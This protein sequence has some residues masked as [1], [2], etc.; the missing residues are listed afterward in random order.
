MT[1]AIILN[2]KSV[3]SQVNDDFVICADGGYKLLKGRKANCVIGDFD[4]L[5]KTPKGIKSIKYQAMKNQTDGE[6]CIEYAIG[7]GYKNINIYAGLGGRID[8]VMGNLSLLTLAYRLGAKA[9]IKDKDTF[10]Y[11]TEKKLELTVEKGDTIS[12]IAF[13]GAAVVKNSTNLRYPLKDLELLPH[14]TRGI[15]NLASDTNIALEVAQGGV[16]VFHIFSSK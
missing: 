6:L 1:A 11:Y 7:Q 2:G 5:E 13:G 14:R 15:S 9:V 8:H 3:C 10:V 12:V 4:S 16:L